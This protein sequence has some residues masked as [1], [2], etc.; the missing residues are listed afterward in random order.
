V[1]YNGL[2][3]A[4]FFTFIPDSISQGSLSY[5]FMD[6]KLK[7][8]TSHLALAINPGN[9]RLYS[10]EEN[11]RLVRLRETEGISWTEIAKYFPSQNILLL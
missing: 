8:P 5:S 4:Y 6:G 3:P 9:H 1:Q 2:E 7:P 11:A 10:S